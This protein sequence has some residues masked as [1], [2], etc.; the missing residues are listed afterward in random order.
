MSKCLLYLQ[1]IVLQGSALISSMTSPIT[2]PFNLPSPA[3]KGI[4]GSRPHNI[5]CENVYELVDPKTTQ[6]DNLLSNKIVLCRKRGKSGNIEQ[7][8]ARF[9]AHGDHQHE[10]IDYDETFMPVVKSASLQVFFALCASLGLHIQQM[11]V[12]GAFLN[13]ILK[14]R[15]FMRQPKGFKEPGK[16]DWVWKLNKALYGLKQGGR[17]WYQCINEFFTKDLGLTHT[18]AD[19]SVYIYQTGSSTTIIPLYVDDLLISYN[20]NDAMLHLKAGLERW[21]KMVDVGPASWVL[22][23]RVSN[24]LRKGTISL[25]QS[26]YIQNV[27]ERFGMADCKPAATPLPEKLVLMPATDDEVLEARSF[28]YLQAIGSVMYAMLGTRPDIAYAVSTLSRFSSWPGP[29]HVQ[30]LKHLLCYLKGSADFGIVYCRDGGTLRGCESERVLCS[31][32]S[33]IMPWT[34][35]AD[36]LSQVPSSY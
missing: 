20:D 30:A 17:E 2:P 24:D 27:V 14:E 23:M 5:K 4:S 32:D 15:V 9:T 8:K 12:T 34:Q 29:K 10:S 18:Y 6:I 28:L 16:E 1:H 35:R 26:L 21:F 31:H 25:N 3:Q 11:D 33:L 22:G 36:A 7:Y 13:G 19:H